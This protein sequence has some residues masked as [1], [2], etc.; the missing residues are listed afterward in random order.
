MLMWRK[1]L[2][3][4]TLT[5]K[6]E[7]ALMLPVQLVDWRQEPPQYYRGKKWLSPQRSQT[8]RYYS[9]LLIQYSKFHRHL[10]LNEVSIITCLRCE[11]WWIRD[12]DDWMA[13]GTSPG[14]KRPVGTRNSLGFP[15]LVEAVNQFYPGSEVAQPVVGCHASVSW[16]YRQDSAIDE[17]RKHGNLTRCFNCPRYAVAVHHT[18]T[19]SKINL[20]REAKGEGA[21]Q[22]VLID[23]KF[24]FNSR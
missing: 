14:E 4:E 18:T 5:L 2:A 23:V 3:N 21:G 22:L 16:S 6:I 8:F 24:W 17:N 1:S 11:R 19:P 7:W 20:K 13:S 9:R 15:Y 12:V 10:P